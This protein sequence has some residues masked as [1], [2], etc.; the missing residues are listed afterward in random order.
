MKFKNAALFVR[1]TIIRHEKGTFGKRSSNLRN[2][3][4]LA[5]RFGMYENILK[6]EFFENNDSTIKC[7]FIVRVFLGLYNQNNRSL[8]RF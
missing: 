2:L 8:V 6:K 4:T 5:L 1:S 7:D 3:K